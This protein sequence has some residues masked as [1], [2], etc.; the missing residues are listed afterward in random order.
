MAEI[1]RDR[2]FF[3]ESRGGVTFS[4]GEPLLQPAFLRELLAACKQEGIHTALDTAG[5]AP[6]EVVLSLLETVD[7]FLFD[8][9]LADPEKH[10][11]YTGV[12]NAPILENL[13]LID[14]AGGKIILRCPVIPGLND[15][16]DNLRELGELATSL[17]SLEKISLLP[18]HHLGEA[19]Y[20]KFGHPYK[21]AGFNSP[22]P[23]EIKKIQSFLEGLGVVVTI[24]G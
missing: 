8:F 23:G 18:Y 7:L 3:D 12:S 13:S 6:R 22:S 17:K 5:F 10:W 4:G 20:K 15:G 16:W 9:K 2:P 19:K 1:L 24:G 14:Q 11:Y 21:L